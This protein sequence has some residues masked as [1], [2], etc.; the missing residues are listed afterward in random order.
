MGDKIKT[1]TVLDQNFITDIANAARLSTWCFLIV[2]FIPLLENNLPFFSPKWKFSL[3]FKI[4]Y[5]NKSTR[6]IVSETAWLRSERGAESKK[7]L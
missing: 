4:D 7:M 2:C 3:Y 1:P 5:A 6:P